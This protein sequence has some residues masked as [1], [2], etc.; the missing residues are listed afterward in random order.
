MIRM[1]R[2]SDEHSTRNRRQPQLATEAR[3]SVSVGT[4]GERF[5]F[6]RHLL[7]SSAIHRCVGAA[8]IA[9]ALWLGFFWATAE[10]AV[11]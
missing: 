7:L 11:R 10:I 4:A 5:I 8:A 6:H 3:P 2:V 9:G 1:F